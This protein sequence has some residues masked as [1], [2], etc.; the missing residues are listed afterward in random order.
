MYTKVDNKVCITVNDWLETGLTINMYKNMSKRGYL[1]I[2]KRGLNGNTLID[3]RSILRP[4]VRRLIEEYF[5]SFDGEKNSQPKPF[6]AVI[7]LEARE[8]FTAFTKPDGNKL[9]FEQIEE[10]V[11]KASLLRTLQKGLYAQRAERA[12]QGASKRINMGDFWKRAVRW[13]GEQ[14]AEFPCSLITNARSLQRAFSAFE[15]DG[16]KSL[17]H[18]NLGNDGARLVSARTE[19]L[20][21][22]I[23]RTQEHPFVNTVHQQ[24]MEFVSGNREMFD[25][26]TG[27]TFKP[28][29]FRHKGRV[30][31]ISEST[32]RHYLKDVLNNTAVYADRNGNFDYVNRLRPK[33]NR[34]VG[35]YSLSKISM[36]DVTLSRKSCRSW[37]NKYIAVD[38]VSGYYFRPAYIVGKPT[39]DTVYEA[40]RNMF[41][42]LLELGLPM[43]GELEVEKHLMKDLNWLDD[44]FSFVRFCESP[45]EK[46]AEHNIKALKYGA[47]KKAGHSRGRWYA[48][49]EAYR[50]V[51][52]KKD[53]DFIEPI[54]Q[55]QTIIAD[56]LTDIEKHNNTLHPRQKT[57]P[58]MTRKEV[59]M[60]NVNPELKSIAEWYLYQFIGNETATTIN[61]SDYVKVNGEEFEL[62]DYATLKRLKVNNRRVTAYWL[63]NA[64]NEVKKVYLYQDGEYLGEAVNRAEFAYNEN[65]IERTDEDRANIVHQSKR[66]AKFDKMIKDRKADIPK[67]G[68]RELE[69]TQELENT[70]LEVINDNPYTDLTIDTET[71]TVTEDLRRR[72]INNL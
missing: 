50:V 60:A 20:L 72:A 36:D 8:F 49:H 5:G 40:F 64:E 41:I 26:D 32:V 23:F 34:K 6:E 61:N 46:R 48:K 18:K 45:T 63:P 51:R 24:Y 2:V 47:S 43:P 7:D 9:S 12:R 17:L 65:A 59:F 4:D 10:Y 28:K 33:H 22:A 29:D 35:S 62:A 56:D 39:H 37:I 54:Y 58:G 14:Q 70:E 69:D 30:I 68:S 1:D 55:P 52:N 25:K 57:Y 21:M 19:A 67:L 3:V 13:Y 42:E 31:G 71:E 11:N 16:Y 27:E 66:L 44:A 53:G 15:K 38:V